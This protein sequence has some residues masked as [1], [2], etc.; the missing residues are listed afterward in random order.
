MKNHS[1]FLVSGLVVLFLLLAWGLSCQAPQG[2]T[3][4]PP[5]PPITW[6]PSPSPTATPCPQ[7]HICPI[8]TTWDPTLCQCLPDP[9]PSPTPTV[10]VDKFMCKVGYH[11]DTTVCECVPNATATPTPSSGCLPCPTCL[12]ANPP[13]L[14]PISLTPCCTPLPTRV[15]TPML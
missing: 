1:L 3:L 14:V 6:T 5:P 8:G 13:C 11:W 9:I 4:P 12:Y 7:I 2:P 10:C 15:V